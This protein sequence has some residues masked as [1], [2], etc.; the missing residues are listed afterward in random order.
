MLLIY[1]TMYPI[2]DKNMSDSQMGARK[3]RDCKNN[4]FIINGIIH[5]VLKSKK[6][7]PVLLQ[8]YDYALKFD[9]I[10]LQKALRDIY[11]YG[12]NYDNLALLPN[13]NEEVEFAVKTSTGLTDRQTAKDIVLQGIT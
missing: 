7:E 12:V 2:I 11:D 3:Q 13:A 6:M 10:D 1:N 5:E 8:I 9:S 4:I